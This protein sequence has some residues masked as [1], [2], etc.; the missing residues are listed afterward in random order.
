MARILI[1]D[2][3][4]VFLHHVAEALKSKGYQVDTAIN[5]NDAI[6]SLEN[7]LYDAVISDMIIKVNDRTVP[8]GGL[9]LINWLRARELNNPKMAKIPVLGISGVA[10]FPGLNTILNMAESVGADAVLEKPMVIDQL[11]ASLE[12]I[13]E[14][15]KLPAHAH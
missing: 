3:D 15:D 12:S 4:L 13:I 2:D 8:S 5:V 6:D 1:M 11:V 9:T 7:V 14:E 10:N